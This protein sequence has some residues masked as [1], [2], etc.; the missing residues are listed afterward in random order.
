M[1]DVQ[2][3]GGGRGCGNGGERG[4]GGGRRW[5]REPRC[6]YCLEWGHV[7]GECVGWKAFTD[8]WVAAYNGTYARYGM[9]P[10]TPYHLR[11]RGAQGQGRGAHQ[12]EPAGPAP[13]PAPALAQTVAELQARIA[14]LAAEV[15]ALAQAL[16]AAQAAAAETGDAA[17]QQNEEMDA[18][19]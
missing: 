14:Q 7:R 9:Q 4:R 2:G 10:P 18:R 8:A 5:R 11:R 12:R 19:E 3:H 15:E 6:N 13:A 17:P 16:A 1:A